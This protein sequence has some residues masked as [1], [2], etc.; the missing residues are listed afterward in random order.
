LAE[1]TLYFIKTCLW[2]FF[3][4]SGFVTDK[5]WAMDDGLGCSALT[6]AAQKVVCII[7][8]QRLG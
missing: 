8:M 7:L 5:I 2:L 1:T 4:Q 3:F 6:R